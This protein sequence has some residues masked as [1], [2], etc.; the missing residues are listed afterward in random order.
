MSGTYIHKWLT[1]GIIL[2]FS[3]VSFA[4][5]PI[6]NQEM[7]AAFKS[8]GLTEEQL[9]EFLSEKGLAIADLQNLSPEEYLSLDKELDEFVAVNAVENFVKEEPMKLE[10]KVQ[11]EDI[12][13]VK[14]EEVSQKQEPAQ[15][16]RY[17]DN[18]FVNNNLNLFEQGDVKSVPGT[19]ILNVGDEVRVSIYGYSKL[20]QIYPVREDG[21][22]VYNNN[23]QRIFVAGL[24]LNEV[25]TKIER[26]F[27]TIYVFKK[28]EIAIDIASVRTVS[29]NIYGEVGNP[30]GYSISAVNSPVNALLAA[31]GV[32]NSGS[33]RNITLLKS[34]GK[35][36]KIDLYKYLDDPSSMPAVSLS[37]NDII[38]VPL[39]NMLVNVKGAVKR[40]LIF[41]LKPNERLAELMAFTGGYLPNANSE[42][43]QIIRFENSAQ[44]II[45]INVNSTEYRSFVLRNG[46]QINV[47]TIESE[48]TNAIS[49]E[50][51]INNA[52]IFEYT[53]GMKVADLLD[54]LV[55]NSNSRTDV[56]LLNRYQADGSS[57]LIK[58]NLDDVMAN[59]ASADNIE[60]E[61]NDKLLIW[62]KKRFVDERGEVF[63]S[64]AVRKPG[65]YPFANGGVNL[66]DVILY[67][68]G[69]RRDAGNVGMIY[70]KDPLNSN[71]IQYI[72]I[73]PELAS[74][75]LGS[76]ANIS[77]MAYDSIVIME[78]EKIQQLFTVSIDGKVRTPGT[79]Q[80]GEGMTLKDLVILANG[81][82]LSALTDQIEVN[83]TVIQNNKPTEIKVATVK[84]DPN[85]A[86]EGDPGSTYILKP[87][88]KIYVRTVPQFELPTVVVLSGEV[89]YPGNYVIEKRN[90]RLMDLINRAGGLTNEA[91]LN[92]ASLERN[93][94]E[95]GQV[96]MNIQEAQ[97]S[98]KSKYNYILK[99]G[100]QI[101]IPKQEDI[102]TIQS[103]SLNER[104]RINGDNSNALSIGYF[105]GKSAKY[106]INEFG[107]GFGENS[108]RAAVYVEHANGEIARTKNYILFN[109]YPKVRKGSTIVIPEK[110]I[111]P[112]GEGDDEKMDWT[113]LLQDSVAQAMSILTLL[114]LVERL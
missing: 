47:N 55:L 22:I 28:G 64:G 76:S 70:R 66:S 21:S 10:T 60:L 65:S 44:K 13:V 78:A 18:L 89:K 27:K 68:G 93:D 35:S 69:L 16:I 98:P 38:H 107:G 15:I 46:D 1:L 82:D 83:R 86:S 34:D 33:Y 19:Y 30:G 96:I 20:E 8:K 2:L 41:E 87:F 74:T 67:S 80:Y 110:D 90:E 6:S 102:V 36:F 61:P 51:A 94:K 7:L 114:L 73:D 81:F 59:R 29:I 48:I 99:P 52:G 32:K 14:M 92:G 23:N 45:D 100:D 31:K 88:D 95:I 12:P 108:D 54:R 104:F 57:S 62:N 109:K 49:A 50:G 106:Y 97:K 71:K 72:K 58:L 91:F 3:I 9:N 85:L 105:P 113:Q 24:N 103:T 111:E 75:D 40:P 17:G 26:I 4:Q 56:V 101:F 77:L 79:F 37:D 5:V 25:R 63:I 43:I 42:V 84:M 39:A 53:E 112:V 11:S